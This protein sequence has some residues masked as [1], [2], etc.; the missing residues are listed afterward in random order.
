MSTEVGR[1]PRID[2]ID[3]LR[4]LIIIVMA[5]VTLFPLCRWYAGLKRRRDDMKLGSSATRRRCST[6][7]AAGS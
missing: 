6:G 4:G 7:L 2:S 5:V 1:R 3:L